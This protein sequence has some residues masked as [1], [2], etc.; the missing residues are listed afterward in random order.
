MRKLGNLNLVSEIFFPF[1]YFIEY[2]TSTPQFYRSQTDGACGEPASK[3]P[4]KSTKVKNAPARI[5]IVEAVYTYVKHGNQE[6]K[7]KWDWSDWISWLDVDSLE[8]QW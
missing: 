5:D 7:M 8:V 1:R 2:V 3:R 6:M 4:K